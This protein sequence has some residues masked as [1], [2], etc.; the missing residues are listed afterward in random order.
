M[1]TRSPR[2]SGERLTQLLVD[3]PSERTS[4][5][6]AWLPGKWKLHQAA[7]PRHPVKF[8]GRSP[9]VMRTFRFLT[10]GAGQG[11]LQVVTAQVR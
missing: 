10:S 1:R 3:L 11:H 6:S 9:K 8:G 2:R 5:L 4:E 7:R